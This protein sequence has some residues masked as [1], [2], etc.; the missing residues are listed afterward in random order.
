LADCVFCFGSSR[1]FEGG[2]FI[3]FPRTPTFPICDY[4]YEVD[5]IEHFFFSI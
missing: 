5:A 4:L 2:T 3:A 1:V